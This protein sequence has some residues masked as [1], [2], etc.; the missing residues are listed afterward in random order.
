MILIHDSEVF[1]NLYLVV[2]KKVGSKQHDIFV[3]WQLDGQYIRD[4]REALREYVKGKFLVGF[5]NLSFD[6]PVL[7]HVI[8][9]KCPDTADIKNFA[10]L[11][12]ESNWPV[13]SEEKLKIPQLDLL[14][15]WHYNNHARYTS[16]K[17]LEFSFHLPHIKD[18]PFE[19]DT[20]IKSEA[21]LNKVIMYCKHDLIPT[22]HFYKLSKE[23]ILLRR[24]VSEMLGKNMMNQPD[25]SLGEEIVMQALS[26]SMNIPVEELYLGRTQRQLINV[27]EVI[28]PYIWN[29]SIIKRVRE[30]YFDNMILHST[31]SSKGNR[32]F[33]FTKVPMHTFMWNNIEVSLGM[34]GIHGCV[35]KGVYESDDE[36]IINTC[37]VKGEYPSII[38]KEDIYPEHLGSGFINTYKNDVVLERDKWPKSTH[39]MMNETYKKA[40]NCVFGKMNSEYSGLYDPRGMVTITVNGQLNKLLLAEMLIKGIPDSKLLMMNTDGLEIKIPRKYITRYNF[41]CHRWETLTKLQLEHDSYKKLVIESVNH[42]IGIYTDNRIKRKGRFCTQEDYN[43]FEDYHKNTSAVIIQEAISEYFHK[44]TPIEDTINNSNN[45]YLFCYGVKKQKNFDFIHI[46]SQENRSITINVYKERVL[47]FYVAKHIEGTKPVT[48]SLFKRWSDGKFTAILKDTT[49]KIAQ[50][51][52]KRK[53]SYTD[54][55]RQYYIDQAYKIVNEIEME[56]V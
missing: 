49:V 14:R 26:K 38:T 24:H 56:D 33:D 27:K 51:I 53:D 23:R 18:L 36:Y 30:E 34:G 54:L 40:S 17:W 19:H 3:I 37:D 41:I 31:R 48:G 39:R 13:I 8:D 29:L 5:N 52:I 46:I 1:P 22:E 45:L 2:F 25:S 28:F 32:V 47:R 6:G 9:A 16:L 7:E 50:R 55:D 21:Q 11:C 43:K 4:D 20:L 44:G 10:N 42:Y 35:N 15:I 12:I